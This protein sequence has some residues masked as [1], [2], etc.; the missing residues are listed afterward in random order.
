MVHDT[1]ARLH[2]KLT[3]WLGMK[4]FSQLIT[5]ICWIMG[6]DHACHPVSLNL[7]FMYRFIVLKP[8]D[9]QLTN[10]VTM[11]SVFK[12]LLTTSEFINS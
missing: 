10:V 1:K 3:N 11:N 2:Q 4:V 9:N 5:Y 12:K 6:K 7:V 8:H